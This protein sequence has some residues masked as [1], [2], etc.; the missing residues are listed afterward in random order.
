VDGKLVLVAIPW[1][2]RF[3]VLVSLR[4]AGNHDFRLVAIVTDQRTELTE[5]EPHGR[6][7]LFR[8]VDDEQQIVTD[9]AFL[10]EVAEK[11]LAAIVIRTGD[12]RQ[13]RALEQGEQQ[14]DGTVPAVAATEIDLV[15]KVRQVAVEHRAL[16]AG[17][18]SEQQ[19]RY[20]GGRVFKKGQSPALCRALPNSI[21][22]WSAKNFLRR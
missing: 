12:R 6:R 14:F 10:V 2:R 5:L 1:H 18:G 4:L 22:R 20:A 19:L 16:A 17:T 11:L 3:Q 13:P 21:R 15:L 9:I 7:D 8:A